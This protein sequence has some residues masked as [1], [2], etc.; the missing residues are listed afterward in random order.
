MMNR[1]QVLGGL[2]GLVAL[3]GTGGLSKLAQAEPEFVEVNDDNYLDEVLEY[4]GAVLVLIYG[5]VGKTESS[6]EISDN[7]HELFNKV[8]ETHENSRVSDKPIKFCKYDSSKNVKTEIPQLIGTRGSG[9]V[10]Y[11]AGEFKTIPEKHLDYLRGSPNDDVI[12]EW[13]DFL[14]NG[15]IPTNLTSPNREWA[16][17]FDGDAQEEKVP[18]SP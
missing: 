6:Q 16:W 3:A 18:Y 1:R 15:W 14:S 4:D 13:A 8:A 7:L 12:Q 5:S 10:M 2:A 11:K 17:R 9:I